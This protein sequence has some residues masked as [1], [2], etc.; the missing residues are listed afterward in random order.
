MAETGNSICE[1]DSDVGK[2]V[3]YGRASG[4][5]IPN[6][7]DDDQSV[8]TSQMGNGLGETEGVSDGALAEPMKNRDN[9]SVDEA[10]ETGNSI[11]ENE[12]D[13][14]KEVVSGGA[15]GEQIPNLHDDDQSV[16]ET[17]QMGNGLGETEGV[18]D[19]ALCEPIKN[20]DDNKSVYEIAETGNNIGE[21]E[22]DVGK[23]VVYGGAS[24]EQIPNPNDYDQSLDENSQMGNGLGETE[25]VSDDALAEPMKNR[26]NKSVDEAAETGNSIRENESDVGKEVVFGGASANKS[27]ICMMMTK[28]F[29]KPHKWEMVLRK[30]K[31]CLMAHYVNQSKI[32]IIT[33]MF[34]KL[35]KQEI[36]LV[37]KSRMSEKKLFMVG[38]QVNK[39]QICMIMTKVLMKP[40]KWEM[41]FVKQ[42]RCLMVH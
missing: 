21:K 2:E 42:K 41:F 18:S 9:K 33:R 3:V 13:V 22:S 14:R 10:A 24:G 17:S 20:H 6:R 8:E 25:A 32:V 7:H 30:Q 34:M 37:K 26:D 31:W 19:G 12:S 15:S 11:R 29:M 23:E 36:V 1:K 16:H 27:Q 39:S 5:Q 28:V 40:H 4:E 38:H 35:Q